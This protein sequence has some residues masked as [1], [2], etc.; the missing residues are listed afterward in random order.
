L[1]PPPLDSSAQTR[2]EIAELVSIEAARTPEAA[3]RAAADSEETVWRFAETLGPKF[4]K[5]SL[6]LV[7]ALFG[8]LHETEGAVVD[9]AKGVFARPRPYRLNDQLHPVAKLSKSASY[10]S[11]HATGGT[12]M[13]IVLANMVPE[14]RRE[15][16]ARAWEYGWNRAVAGVHYRSDIEAGRIA[17]SVIAQALFARDDFRAQYEAARKE[18]RFALGLP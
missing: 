3:A 17:G 11:G 16:M 14:K 7:G 18:L 13:G 15:I 9:P 12:L 1:P 6:P 4:T 5:E 8:R 2:S 10:P